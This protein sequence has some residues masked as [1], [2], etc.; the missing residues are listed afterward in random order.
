MTRFPSTLALSLLLGTFP[1][2][3]QDGPEPSKQPKPSAEGEKKAAAKYEEA[4]NR[5]KK[6]GDTTYEL[7][8]I[9]FNSATKEV[10]IPTVLNMN[11]GILEYVL[12]TEQGKTHES[13][14]RTTISP[15][16]L[17]L[18]LLL[19]SYEPH[20]GEAAKYLAAPHPE[21]KAMID[22]P[23]EKAGANRIQFTAQWKDKSGKEQT[24]PLANWIRN[25]MTKTTLDADHWTYT[26]S[27]I[28]LAGFASEYDGSIG[29]LY[30]DLG[31]MFNC[32]VKDNVNDDVWSAE[33]SASPP[34]DTPVTLIITPFS[35]TPVT[36]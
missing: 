6:T 19:C 25:R 26:G 2:S 10:R 17:N 5:I 28:N 33:T 27:V 32:P 21:T 22:K 15:T 14:L 13:L 20:I 4:K 11:E 8:D 12:V 34:V 36:K 31:A 18:A 29:A 9:K 16:E 24:A 35:E 7:G 23:M 30:F 3:A 1:L